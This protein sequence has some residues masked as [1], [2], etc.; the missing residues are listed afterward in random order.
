MACNISKTSDTSLPEHGVPESGG[1]SSFWVLLEQAR[2]FGD[3]TMHHR[4]NRV[5][6]TARG[7]E[8]KGSDF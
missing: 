5:Y 6:I 8:A 3:F 1:K 4:F 2:Q 7:D